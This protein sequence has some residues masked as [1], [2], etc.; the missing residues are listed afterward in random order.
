M[1]S[2]MCI[3]DRYSL[4][5]V[6]SRVAFEELGGPLA[7]GPDLGCYDCLLYTSDAADDLP[8]VDLGGRRTITKKTH[9]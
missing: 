9:T 1:G 7:V 3:R 4:G 8:R 5:A 6:A 2:E